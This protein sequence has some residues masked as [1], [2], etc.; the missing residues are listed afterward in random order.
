MLLG[1]SMT[2]PC[3][4]LTKSLFE[5]MNMDLC[6]KDISDKLFLCGVQLLMIYRHVLEN[7]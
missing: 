4:E 6:W 3:F 7:E 2:K 1:L 5:L